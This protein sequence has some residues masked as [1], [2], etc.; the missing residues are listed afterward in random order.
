MYTRITASTAL[1]LLVGACDV[2][3]PND[4]DLG[5]T[6]GPGGPG[7]GTESPENRPGPPGKTTSANLQC[8]LGKSYTGIAAKPLDGA[9]IDGTV[10]SERSRIKPFSALLGEYTR[11]L[12]RKPASLDGYATTFGDAPPHWYYETTASAISV[13]SAYSIAFDGCLDYTKDATK[14]GQNPTS[15]TAAT[16]CAAMAKQF[17]NRN[18]SSE[19]VAACASF[20][21]SLPTTGQQAEP[22]ANHQWAAVCASVLTAAGFLAY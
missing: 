8:Q 20:A 3:P 19:E 14:Y 17:W 1:L 9:R 4:L 11:V 16:A 10:F 2:T 22:D 13:S 12:G 15:A 5:G 7:S 6:G 21:T 18:A